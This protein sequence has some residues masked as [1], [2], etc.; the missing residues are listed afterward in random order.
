VRPVRH[1]SEAPDPGGEARRDITSAATLAVVLLAAV[2]LGV[3]VARREVVAAVGVVALA[4]GLLMAMVVYRRTARL[5]AGQRA[6]VEEEREGRER[7]ER[8]LAATRRFLETESPIELRRQICSVALEVFDCAAVSLWAVEDGSLLLLERVP[9]S[10]PYRGNE[11]RPI[12]ELPGLREALDSGQPLF[13]P[14]LETHSAGVTRATAEIVGAGSLLD[15]PI[16][17]GGVTRLMLGLLWDV[18]VAEPVGAP[19]IAAQRFADQA[20]LALEQARYRAA[21][22]EIAS[23]NRTLRAMVQTDP[24]FRAH[25]TIGEVSEAICQR[26]REVFGAS[27]VALWTDAGDAIEL[28]HRVPAATILP[29]RLQIAFAEHPSFGDDLASGHPRF[30]ADVEHEDPVLWERFARRSG[31]RSQLRIPLGSAGQARSLLVMSWSE[32]VPPPSAEVSAIASRFADQAGVALAEAA[33]RDAR[34]EASELHARFERSLLPSIELESRSASVATFYRPGDGRLS[35]GGDFYDCLELADGSIALLIG[36]VA[37]HGAAAAALGAGLRSAWR[38]LVLGGWRPEQLPAGL[39]DFC[40]RERQ[41][42]DMFVTAITALL[43]PD[44]S[45]LSF[46]SAGHP[47]PLLLGGDPVDASANGPPLGAVE[48]ATWSAV[49]VGLAAEASV[50]LFTDG[51]VEGHAAPDSGDRLGVEAIERLVAAVP[52]GQLL[53]P[54]LRRLVVAAT[55]ANGEGLEDDVALLALNVRRR[56]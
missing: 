22:A 27:G 43:A 34:R 33:R 13:V 20:G 15:V 12:A 7:L 26:A 47:A 17:V 31:S 21:Q 44:R 5:A 29:R 48:D 54:D 36:D 16:A 49:T 53:E 8:T 2:L 19:R 41:D 28:V 1:E 52:P 3:L 37:G 42:P 9:W 23:L 51:L 11:R 39:Q 4:T 45:A 55:K 14:D 56:P 18:V 35:L 30:V 25:G 24:L 6:V 32:A 38:A 10:H 50:L 40:V 46:L